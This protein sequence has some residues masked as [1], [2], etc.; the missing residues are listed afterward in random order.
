[1][2]RYRQPPRAHL[3]YNR[4]YELNIR[5]QRVRQN[6]IV[7]WYI[8]HNFRFEISP[9][10][11]VDNVRPSYYVTSYDRD[12]SSSCDLRAIS[13]RT[14]DVRTICVGGLL[15]GVPFACRT[16]VKPV[17]TSCQ[18][19]SLSYIGAVFPRD[20]WD[21][22]CLFLS[23]RRSARNFLFLYP[24]SRRTPSFSVSGA[25]CARVLATK[26]GRGCCE[27]LV[28]PGHQRPVVSAVF[29]CVADPGSSFPARR[30]TY[31]RVPPASNLLRAFVIIII[32]V[33]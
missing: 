21:T 7:V 12:C 18:R 20:V 31:S 26:I 19:P 10:F 13:R 22:V 6:V 5:F 24:V 2:A 32:C 9:C 28:L 27:T 4:I 1:M 16:T 29:R 25:A 33:P 15:R 3:I 14:R 23:A 8:F 11:P 30:G 17:G